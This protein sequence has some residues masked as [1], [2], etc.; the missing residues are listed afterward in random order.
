[1]GNMGNIFLPYT[2]AHARAREG[3]AGNKFPMFPTFPKPFYIRYL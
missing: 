1:M 3:W 2:R